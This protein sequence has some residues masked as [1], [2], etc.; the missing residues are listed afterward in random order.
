MLGA[1]PDAA[2]DRSAHDRSM[3]LALTPI[4]TTHRPADRSVGGR[5]GLVTA[6]IVGLVAALLWTWVVIS[7]PVTGPASDAPT[8]PPSS[9]ELLNTM[10]ANR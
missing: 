9:A 7:G 10:H 4:S 1:P 3:A 8:G 2:V 6:T 5:R